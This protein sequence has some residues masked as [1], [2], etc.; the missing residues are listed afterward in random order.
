MVDNIDK[1]RV[2]QELIEFYKNVSQVNVGNFVSCPNV[3]L[4]F[5]R[6]HIQQ[7]VD[8]CQYLFTVKDIMGYVEIWRVKY[9]FEVLRV[10]NLVFRD[11]DTDTEMKE[12]GQDLVEFGHSMI[13]DWSQIRDDSTLVDL[14]D[15][16]DL[17]GIECLVNS[18]D[19]SASFIDD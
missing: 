4:E 16:H 12:D 17:E 2:E 9:A 13:S 3:V 7:V 8:N 5:N 10:L 11:I 6:F 14:L 15:S 19:A 1:K 18:F